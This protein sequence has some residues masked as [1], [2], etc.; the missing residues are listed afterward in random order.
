MYR[1]LLSTL[2]M[3]LSSIIS[4]QP[5]TDSFLLT[6]LKTAKNPIVDTVLKHPQIFRCQVVYTQIERDKKNRPHFRNFYFNYDS[7][8][9]FNPASMVK[10]P[11]ALLALEKLKG[12]KKFG[13]DKYTTI[14]FDSSYAGQKTMYRDSTSANGWP[15]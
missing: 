11:L 14:Q 8:L 15:S 1:L 2:V 10:L 4:A 13:I 5:K 9:Y 3:F 7:Q 6:I 12:L